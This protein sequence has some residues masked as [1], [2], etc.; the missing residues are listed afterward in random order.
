MRTCVLV[1]MGWYVALGLLSFHPYYIY[2]WYTFYITLSQQF[3]IMLVAL[4]SHTTKSDKRSGEQHIT[5]WDNVRGAVYAWQ[6][7]C[8]PWNNSIQYKF[9]YELTNFCFDIGMPSIF[10]SSFPHENCVMKIVNRIRATCSW[11]LKWVNHLM[12]NIRMWIIMSQFGQFHSIKRSIENFKASKKKMAKD[13]L[14]W[15]EWKINN[16]AFCLI[17]YV[18]FV[19]LP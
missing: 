9:T 19:F 15:T 16:K 14:L 3:L 11:Q 2:I 5:V 1:C 18:F 13:L 17:H 4:F 10:I 8:I 7:T 12:R 6:H